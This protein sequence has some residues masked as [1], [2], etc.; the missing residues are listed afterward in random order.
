MEDTLIASNEDN[1]IVRA[2]TFVDT[3]TGTAILVGIQVAKTGVEAKA[4]GYT[5]LRKDTGKRNTR[6]LILGRDT[7]DLKKSTS[8]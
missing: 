1:T 3:E 6:S 5:I 4:T 7:K 2:S 8:R